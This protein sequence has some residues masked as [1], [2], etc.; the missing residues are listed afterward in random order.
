MT[1]RKAPLQTH[2]ARRSIV[3]WDLPVRIFHWLL[4]GLVILQWWTGEN[5]HMGVHRTS[6]LVIVGLLV[7]RI[8]WGVVG[9][10]TARF[11]HFVKGPRAV[12]AYIRALRRPY[13]P[14][15]GH[16]PVGA[17][18]VVAMLLALTAQ[19]GTGLFAVDVDGIE[20]GPLSHLVS[21]E[22]GR[23]F[24]EIHETSFYALVALIVV[25]LAAIAFYFF[26]L[27]TNLISAMFTGRRQ[28]SPADGSVNIPEFPI[29]R[30]VIGLLLAASAVAL[31]AS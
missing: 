7:F 4:A 20:S 16:N 27:R 14:S 13:A 11:T 6:G 10:A 8:Y 17:L 23:Q 15:A 9:P 18:S 19:V 29:V 30:V 21:F 26:A 28:H 22:L 25:H 31:I 24:A 12:L 3:I 2:E 5:G 1:T